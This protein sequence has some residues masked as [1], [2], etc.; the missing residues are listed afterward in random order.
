MEIL[1]LALALVALDT[2]VLWKIHKSKASKIEKLIFY[3]IVILIPI[4]GVSLYYL[5]RRT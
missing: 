3:F 5:F 2:A 4:F 1:F